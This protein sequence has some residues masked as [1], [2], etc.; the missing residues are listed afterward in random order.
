MDWSRDKI[1]ER[2]TRTSVMFVSNPCVADPRVVSEARSLVADG[3]RVVVIAW[4]HDRKHAEQQLND[5]IDIR[6]VHAGFR[7]RGGFGSRIWNGFNLLLW[8]WHAYRK[9]I[10][11][12]QEA[13]TTVLHCH[14]LDTLPAGTALKLRLGL[15]LVYDAHEVY[16]YMVSRRL[17]WRV[18]MVFC[19]LERRLLRWVDRLITVN[20][21]CRDYFGAVAR[22]PVT[23]V[24]NCKPLE[25]REYVAPR[26]HGELR[27]LYVGSLHTGRAIPM[28]VRATRNLD[29]VSV[30]VGGIG[31]AEHVRMI[32]RECARSRNASFVGTVPMDEVIPLTKKADVVFLMVKPSDANNRT[33]LGNKQFEAMVCGRPIICTKGTYSGEVTE[34]EQ[35]GL[36]VDFDEQALREA[37]VRLRD[38]PA[39]REKLGR[40]AL[41]AALTKYNWQNEERK[42]L[43]LYDT[44][45]AGC[46]SDAAEG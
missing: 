15:P 39:L 1:A 13:S 31:T 23:V 40:N 21:P 8:Q 46:A 3:W 37:V 41:N 35:V 4:D 2:Q 16:G 45:I 10:S 25:G 18:A 12:A 44:L 22:S 38:D 17:P 19:W 9:G 32:A 6:R 24:M 5:G 42:L 36:A 14:D 11:V 26:N 29:G 20:E 34:R 43:Q 28:L 33:G 7:P 30:V 27:I